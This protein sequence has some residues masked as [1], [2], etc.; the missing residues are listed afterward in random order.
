MSVLSID[1]TLVCEDDGRSIVLLDPAVPLN[2]ID[3]VEYRREP[4][5]RFNIDVTFLKSAPV[6]ATANCRVTGGVRIVDLQVVKIET[7]ATDPLM[8]RVLV[9][10]EGDFSL[11]VLEIDVAGLDKERNEAVFSFKATCPSEF[12]CRVSRDCENDHGEEPA[13]DYLAKDYQSFRRLM[14]D[15]IAERNPNWIERLPADLG[16]TLVELLA[17]AGDYLSYYQ[18]AGPG[19]ESFLDTCLHRV[20]AARHGR[21][22]DYHMGQ[23]QSAQTYIHLGAAAGTNS[24]APT[25]TKLASKI[26]QPLMGHVLPPGLMLPASADFDRDPAL[27]K[28]IV[29]ELTLNVR[30]RDLHN[31]LLIHTWGDHLCCLSRETSTLFLYADQSGTAVRPQFEVGELLLIEEIR[32]PVTGLGGDADPEHRQ[33]MVIANIKD[34]WD[35]AFTSDVTGGSL[36]PRSNPGD[37]RLPL[38]RIDFAPASKPHFAICVSAETVDN[39]PI[40][41][42]TIVRGNIGICNHGRSVLRS[43]QT[44]TL[45]WPDMG[46]GRWPVPELMLPD[47]PITRSAEAVAISLEMTFP[48]EPAE[49]WEPEPHLLDSLP[50]DQSFVAELDNAGV[51]TLRFG[52]DQYGRRPFDATEVEARYRIG[53]GT[54][55]NLGWGR[56]QHVVNGGGFPAIT[57]V[58][59]PLPATGGAEPETIEQVRQLAPEA[60][61]AVQFRAV[62]EADWME[63]ALRNPAIAAAKASFHWTGSWHTVFIAINPKDPSQLLHLPGGGTALK[64]DFIAA[65]KAYFTRF[66]LAGY[67]INVQAA[68]FVPLEIEI[69]LC[70]DDGH[71]RGEVLARVTDV[72]SNRQ[73]AIGETGFFHPLRFGFGDAVYLSQVYAVAAGVAGVSSLEIKM[74]K[75]Y[76]DPPRDELAR[77]LVAMSP[78]EIPRLD[79]DRNFAE[80]GVLRLTA[81]GGL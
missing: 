74:F 81:V 35:D 14:V 60:F 44:G 6:V 40:A 10:R 30:V 55:G 69:Q 51:T 36:K 45:Q 24:I 54:V 42:V 37:P 73:L 46:A 65:L 18:D 70:V 19:T 41:P 7:V 43:T 61:R 21:L 39:L 58:W 3:Y 50:Y 62:T 34:T 32:S 57:R 53:G 64:P 9:D 71:F 2:G 27:A 72:L 33:V 77:G 20:S 63:V 47:G 1:G 66:K 49:T 8:L 11:Y 56:L 29:F 23:G 25:G 79:N 48:G 38:Q 17:Y 52:D 12:D 75:R 68:I 4:L 26:S 80:N 31:E 76:W 67:D 16:M 13:L 59:Q 78:F 5:N 15:L 22:I 28:S